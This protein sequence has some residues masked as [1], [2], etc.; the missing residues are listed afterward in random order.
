MLTVIRD[1]VRA[2]IKKGMTLA[3][4]KAERPTMDYDGLYDLKQ[5]TADQF[6]ETVYKSLAGKK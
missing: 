5:P 6:V 3:Q 2:M 4:V 1:R